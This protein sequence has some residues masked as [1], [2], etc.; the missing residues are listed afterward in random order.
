MAGKCETCTLAGL[1][2]Q[3]K[4]VA[5]AFHHVPSRNSLTVALADVSHCTLVTC[6]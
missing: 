5:G 6:L 1:K 3:G 2:T 4:N